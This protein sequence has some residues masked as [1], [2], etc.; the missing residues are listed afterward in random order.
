[1]KINLFSSMFILLSGLIITGCANNNTINQVY[2]PNEQLDEVLTRY[3]K[4][5][6]ESRQCEAN[7]Q[8]LSE[9]CSLSSDGRHETC[10]KNQINS[11]NCTNAT[12]Q[13]AIDTSKLV[14]NLNCHDINQPMVDCFR[15]ASELSAL[16]LKY[17]NHQ[18]V[19]MASALVEFEI[20][21]TGASQQL[22]DL[23]LSKRGAY[24]EAAILRSRI[25]MEEGNLSLARAIVTRQLNITPYESNLY[26]LQAAYYYLEGKYSKALL[27]M[28][29][30]ERFMGNH[31]RI[32]YHRGII[33][34]AQKEWYKACKEYKG[35]LEEQPSNKLL[36]AKVLLLREHVPCRLN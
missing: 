34:E 31:W 21:N 6:Q 27:S 15:L 23:I 2:A 25:A 14:I 17:P 20:G 1:M 7:Q 30:A 4:I 12:A 16:Y 9:A 3:V 5:K 13:K 32:G 10:L 35:V 33:Y 28:T 29:S 22:L 11:V 24:P 26:E 18:R 36:N 8:P 19:I